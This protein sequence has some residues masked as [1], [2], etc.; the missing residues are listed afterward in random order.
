MLNLKPIIISTITAADER[1]QET[2]INIEIQGPEV[3]FGFAN[4]YTVNVNWKE[5]K[6]FSDKKMEVMI[7]NH[8]KLFVNIGEVIKIAGSR[9]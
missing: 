5:L 8:K 6:E 7:P 3:K 2:L 1:G 4:P 9:V